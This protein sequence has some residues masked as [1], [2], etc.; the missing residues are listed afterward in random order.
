MGKAIAVFHL[1]ATPSARMHH[2]GRVS[3]LGVSAVWLAYRRAIGC[4]HE[5][6]CDLS[7]VCGTGWV[8]D[9]AIIGAFAGG[10]VL[11]GK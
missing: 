7:F 10:E 2:T 5:C 1:L 3:A 6:L 9:V 8:V 11:S 4:Q